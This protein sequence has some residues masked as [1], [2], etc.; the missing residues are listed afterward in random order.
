[1]QD[2]IA[3][4]TKK[5]YRTVKNKDQSFTE[6]FKD[7]LVE[8]G[9]IVFAITLSIWLHGWQ[10]HKNQQTEAKEFLEDLKVDLENDIADLEKQNAYLM[11][12]VEKCNLFKIPKKVDSL[13]KQKES[14]TIYLNLNPVSKIRNT[15]NYEGFK[16]SGKIAFIENRQLKKHILRYYQQIVPEKDDR[17]V[18]YNSLVIELAKE[19]NTT[20]YSQ[21]LTSILKSE[22]AKGILDNCELQAAQI[23]EIN[24]DVIKSAKEIIVEIESE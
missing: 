17:Q 16:S 13:L 18:Y 9:I 1:M 20:D 22:K 10:E 15:G 19:L 3:K 8:I 24:K 11:T 4:H 6:K 2:E 21:F 5:V 23:A 12:T 14:D 7:V